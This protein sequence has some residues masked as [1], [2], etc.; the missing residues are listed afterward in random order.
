[1][2]KA[3]PWVLIC[4]GIVLLLTAGGL[5]IYS[6]VDDF[7]AGQRAESVLRQVMD[8]VWDLTDISDPD[9][10]FPAQILS[11]EALENEEEARKYN[12]QIENEVIDN[13]GNIEEIEEETEEATSESVVTLEYSV[14]GV[15]EIPK[16]NKKLPVLDRSIAALLN[17]SVCRYSGRVEEKPI[18]LVIAG[19]NLK[20]HF[21][22]IKSLEE[23]DEILFTTRE[24][25]TFRYRMIGFDECHKSEEEAVQAGDGWDITLL[26]CE[27]DRTRRRLVRF[28]EVKY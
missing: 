12:S 2:K 20:S 5:L 7:L 1:M 15:I 8:D 10:Y 25:E 11:A 18:R 26:T 23:G 3:T 21:G 6:R 9:L 22:L 24:A 16:L 28:A 14:I 13:N 27:K 4:A 19:H 17:I